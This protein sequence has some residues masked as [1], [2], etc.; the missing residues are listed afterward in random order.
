MTVT[1]LPP[2]DDWTEYDALALWCAKH[3]VT[4]YPG[5]KL[6]TMVSAHAMRQIE[7]DPEAFAVRV[8]ACAYELAMDS[9]EEIS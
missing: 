7:D 6:P 9:H 1:N 2:L 5:T 4:G 8:R 3:Q